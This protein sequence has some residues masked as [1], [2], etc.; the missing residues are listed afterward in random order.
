MVQPAE[1]HDP[2][3]AL[4]ARLVD[5]IREG[6]RLDRLAEEPPEGEFQTE[7]WAAWEAADNALMEEI[8]DTDADTVLGAQVKLWALGLTGGVTMDRSITAQLRLAHFIERTLR[9]AEA[10]KPG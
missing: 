4:A 10:E 9:R 1:P 7:A 3:P 6:A 5:V 2:W 8:E